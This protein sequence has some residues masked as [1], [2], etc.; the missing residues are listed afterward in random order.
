LLGIEKQK[1]NR[2]VIQSDDYLDNSTKQGKVKKYEQEI[3]QMAYKL[4]GLTEEEI[5]NVEEES[6]GRK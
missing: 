4:Y 5:K 3:D 2:G 6:S 1:K